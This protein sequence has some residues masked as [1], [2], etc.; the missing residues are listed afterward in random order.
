MTEILEKIRSLR[1]IK[2]LTIRHAA[3]KRPVSG[4]MMFLIAAFRSSAEFA[5]TSEDTKRAYRAYLKMIEEQFGDMP[6]AALSDPKVRGEFKTWRDKMAHTARKADYAWST[7]ARV[8]SVAKDRGQ[9]L[10]NP[11]ER[12]GRIYEADRTEQI[13]SEADI[14]K[15]MSVASKELHL[16]LMMALWTGQRHGDLLALQWDAYDG[17]TIRLTQSESKG[18]RA[19]SIKVGLGA[20]RPGAS[21][22]DVHP[23]QPEGCSMDVRWLPDVV[24]QDGRQGRD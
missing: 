16:A 8:L 19:V 12:G 20:A 9:V 1:E 23:D 14:A 2:I 24:G 4:T 22:I 10:V 3:Q 11:C 21:T 6:I 17:T 13:W 18:K 5:K 7:L 15:A